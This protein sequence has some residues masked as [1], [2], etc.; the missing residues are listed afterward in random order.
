M[1]AE[2]QK[3]GWRKAVAQFERA[4]LPRSVFQLANTILPYLAL[5]VAMYFSLRVSYWLTLALAVPA[6]GFLVRSFIIFHDCG[7]GSFFNSKRANRIAEF[8]TGLLSFMPAHCWSRSHATHHATSGDLDRRGVGD[9][10]TLTLKEYRERGRWGRLLYRLYRH[11]ASLLIFG[12]VFIFLM[13]YR[14]WKKSDDARHRRHVILTNLALAAIMLAA[15]LTIGF[16]AYVLIQGPILMLAGAG[17]IWL[18]YVQHQ[19]DGTYWERH[20]GWDYAT[21]ALHGS[22]YYKLPR[23]LQWFSGNIGF[24][25]VHHLSPRIPNYF[26]E[27]CH[28]SSEIFR[29]IR[30]LTMRASLSCMRLRLWDEDRRML[31]G[32]D[33]V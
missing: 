23:L 24:H 4:S 20:E 3:A 7:H 21:Q 28:E 22:S 10:M 8:W 16:K 9:I 31:V 12:P 2:P 25:H 14:V 6:A 32:F 19:F 33:A 30:P 5:L 1:S 18:F 11:P 29:N 13:E 26:L 27:K 15:S 17:G